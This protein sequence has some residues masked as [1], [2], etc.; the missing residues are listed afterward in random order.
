[1][2]YSYSYQSFLEAKRHQNTGDGFVPISLSSDL[3]DFQRLLTE[4]AIRQ[5]RGAIFAN[6]GL[7]KTVMQLVWAENVVAYTNRPVL[8]LAPLAVCPQNE[9]EGEKFGIECH[10]SR[11]GTIKPGINLTNYEKLHHFQADDFSG[12][13]CDES[14]ILKSFD[15]IRRAAI[16][17]FM[18]RLPYRLLCTATPSPNDYVELGTSSE[19]LGHLGHMDMLTRFFKNKQNTIDTKGH[20]R[21]HA[22]PRMFEGQQWRFKGHAEEPFWRWV[23][24]WARAVRSPSDMGCEDSEFLLPPLKEQQHMVINRKQRDGMLFTLPSVGLREQREERR[25]TISERCEKAADLVND[26]KTAVVWCHLNAEGD[27]LEKLITDA[28]QISGKDKDEMKEEKFDAFRTEQARV[29]VIK[30][31]IGAWGLN[32]QHCAHVVTFPSHSFEQYYQSIRRCWRY[33]QTQ[34][35]TVDIVTTEG[36]RDVLQNLQRKQGAAD[37]M[38]ASLVDNMSHELIIEPVSSFT[39]PEEN[40]SWLS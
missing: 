32:W 10:H 25:L 34:S 14:A 11:D 3:K 12:L 31:K 7:G 13:V 36:E 4:W 18:R 28:I 2:T 30:P 6:T 16:T 1:M 40:P 5:G 9:Q 39:V 22:A 23:C 24:S 33:G 35:V 20:Y 17:E 8:I 21:G 15:G 19:A 27:L 26:G 38:F 29:L 37:R